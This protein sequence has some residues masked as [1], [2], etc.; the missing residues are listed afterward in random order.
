MEYGLS[1]DAGRDSLM[2]RDEGH[3]AIV[4]GPGAGVTNGLKAAL[5]PIPRN[6][7]RKIPQSLFDDVE[8]RERS[9]IFSSIDSLVG[10]GRVPFSFRF[11][12]VGMQTQQR[13]GEGI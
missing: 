3:P 5:F 13:K 7:S 11:Q 4:N 6:H 2:G 12:D 10:D 1:T 9:S 8:M